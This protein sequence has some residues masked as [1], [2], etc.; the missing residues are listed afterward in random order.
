MSESELKID[1]DLVIDSWMLKKNEMK[2]IIFIVLCI[3]SLGLV[4]ILHVY[5]EFLLSY[6]YDPVDNID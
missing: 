4:Y 3:L 6:Y 2:K 5:R 1:L